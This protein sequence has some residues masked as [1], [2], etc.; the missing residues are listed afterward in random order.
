MFSRLRV[1]VH[2]CT[3]ILDCHRR[4]FF[5]Y[6]VFN[7]NS[8]VCRRPYT[9][10]GT[11]SQWKSLEMPNQTVVRSRFRQLLNTVDD[12]NAVRKRFRVRRFL[13]IRVRGSVKRFDRSTMKITRIGAPKARGRKGNFEAFFIVFRIIRVDHNVRNLKMYRS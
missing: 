12:V 4:R 10:G 1:R 11:R 9:N 13:S 5:A 6:V 8:S 2:V 3:S 7:I